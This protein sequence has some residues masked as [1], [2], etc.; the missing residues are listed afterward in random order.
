MTTV[1]EETYNKTEAADTDN[2]FLNIP[3][4]MDFVIETVDRFEQLSI[5]E[6]FD[7]IVRGI[8]IDHFLKK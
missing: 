1:K 6:Q 4:E 3:I 7:I 2:G 8:L 5:N